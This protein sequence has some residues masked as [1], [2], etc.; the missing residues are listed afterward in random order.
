[1][2]SRAAKVRTDVPNNL[3]DLT[4]GGSSARAEAM[5]LLKNRAVVASNAILMEK[6]PD[7]DG[8]PAPQCSHRTT[9]LQAVIDPA[10]VTSRQFAFG[11]ERGAR[12]PGLGPMK[13]DRAAASASASMATAL[14]LLTMPGG[15]LAGAKN[16]ITR[17]KVWFIRC[18]H[19][20]VLCKVMPIVIFGTFNTGDFWPLSHRHERWPINHARRPRRR[21]DAFILD[22]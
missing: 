5:S 3:N 22:G 7:N 9:A 20:G 19:Q 8:N 1:M 11:R 21:E 10:P 16:W 15:V 17:S 18:R 14:S 6:P 4:S 2:E 13:R 12:D